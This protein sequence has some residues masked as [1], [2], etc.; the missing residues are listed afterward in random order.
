ML[1]RKPL[2][3]RRW[4]WRTILSLAALFLIVGAVWSYAWHLARQRCDAAIADIRA[5]GEPVLISDLSFASVPNEQNALWY[6]NQAGTLVP[7]RRTATTP[8]PGEYTEADLTTYASAFDL[9]RQARQCSRSSM[10]QPNSGIPPVIMQITNVADVARLAGDAAILAHQKGDDAAALERWQE[11]EVIPRS[12]AGDGTY[13][14]GGLLAVITNGLSTEVLLHIIPTL[15]LGEGGVPLA[16]AEKLIR[17]LEDDAG[18]GEACARGF[19]TERVS[20]TDPYLT[21]RWP[22][23]AM[24]PLQPLRLR[25]IVQDWQEIGQAAAEC[26]GAAPI[27]RTLPVIERYRIMPSIPQFRSSSGDVLNALVRRRLATAALALR[28]HYAKTGRYPQTLEELVP[29]YLSRVPFDPRSP[30][31]RPLG[32]ALLNDGQRPVLWCADP[33]VL[34]PDD[35]IRRGVPTSPTGV[36]PAKMPPIVFFDASGWAPAPISA[37]APSTQH[38]GH[39]QQQPDAP[40]KQ[41]KPEQDTR[42]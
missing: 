10:L 12:F 5:R 38:A 35:V 1:S 20:M 29:A 26:R 9:L 3:A 27:P 19:L 28:V 24:L 36:P 25:H 16:D 41:D 8:W 13:L 15:R 6:I 21:G 22:L 32:Y 42:Q 23:T 11:M 33:P 7:R 34:T 14:I 2:T 37:R 4:I 40:R 17:Q 18:P 31:H 30:A 39:E